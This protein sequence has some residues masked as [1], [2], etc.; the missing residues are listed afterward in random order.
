MSTPS[1]YTMGQLKAYLA[2]RAAH[3]DGLGDNADLI[4]SARCDAFKEIIGLIEGIEA[5][6]AAT[7]G[8]KPFPALTADLAKA[9]G[10]DDLAA[11]MAAGESP[12]DVAMSQGPAVAAA[13]APRTADM[14]AVAQATGG[15][16]GE[17]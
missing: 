16:N 4:Q 11:R 9:Q 17:A 8:P 10:F 1:I 15:S 7:A 12:L 2:A 14:D 13:L 3:I 6:E 5:H